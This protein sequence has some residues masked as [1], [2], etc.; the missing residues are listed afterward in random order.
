ME[1]NE[2][3]NEVVKRLGSQAQVARICGVTSV[4]VNHWSKSGRIPVAR[5]KAIEKATGINRKR[6][7]PDI[8]K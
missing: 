3:F 1:I 4:A 5:C 7:R 8:F 2:I 6:L